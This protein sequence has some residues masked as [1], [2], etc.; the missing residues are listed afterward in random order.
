MQ[1]VC[2][3]CQTVLYWG[4]DQV[5]QMGEKSVLP[6]S[7]SRLFMFAAGSLQGIGF[8]VTGHLRYDHGRGSWDEWFLQMDDGREAWVSEDERKLT[9]EVGAQPDQELPSPQQLRPG[10]PISLSG[11]QYTVREV[12]QATTVG[13]E[14]QMPFVMRPGESY[15]YADLAS[16]DGQQFATLEYDQGA[17]PTCFAGYPLSHDQITIQDEKPPATAAP[18]EGGN[19]NCTNCSAP[20]EVPSGRTVETKVCEYCGAQLDLTSA[21][22]AVL[23]VN[24]KDYDPHFS[25]EIGQKGTF[26]GKPYEV[27]GRM[28]YEDD[29]GYQ[30]REYLLFNAEDSYLWLAEEQGHFVLNQPTQQAP[31]S[32]PFSMV[33]KQKVKIGPTDFQFYE[34]GMTTQIWVDGALPWQAR[35]GDVFQYADLI[36]PPQMFGVESDGNELEYFH[37]R[38]MTPQEVFAAFTITDRAPKTP[39]GVHAAQPYSRSVVGQTIMWVG[40]LLALINGA[41][42]GWSMSKPGS[43]VLKEAFAA[44]DYLNEVR[45]KQFKLSGGGVMSVRIFAPLRNSWISLNMAFLN[46]EKQEVSAEIQDHG[47]EYYSGYSGGESW[48]E[49][50]RSKA[51]YFRAP[52][53]GTYQLVIKASGGSGLRGAPRRENV[54]VRISEGVVLSR[55]FLMAFFVSLLLGL[56]AWGRKGAHERKRWAAVMDDDDDDDDD[57]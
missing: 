40:L 7:D 27:C 57:D 39:W 21:E 56:W 43:E 19:I 44:S 54:V 18:S 35:A 34:A 42:V 48:S 14:G 5:L 10:M 24:P 36:A 45:S 25:F 17:T 20:L 1:V 16:L 51:K 32:D 52:K 22:K 38:Y 13:G 49:G 50:T 30:S 37:G 6:E 55:Y 47:I 33:P 41:L 9:L 2:N 12:G 28:L 11:V 31:T 53:A 29:E 4:Q 26:K 23:G 8:Q 46:V 3:F 15:T